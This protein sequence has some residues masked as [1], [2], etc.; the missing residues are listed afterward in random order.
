MNP[1]ER[2]NNQSGFTLVETMVAVMI[3]G[4]ALGACVMSFSMAMRATA[5]AGNQ[6]A[7]LHVARD[8][9]ETLRTYSFGSSVLNAGTYAFTNG[10]FTGSYVI[11]NVNSATKNVTVNVAYINRIRRGYST[12][13]LVTS[14]TSTLHP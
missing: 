8:Q 14:L 5:T 4:I 3:L 12:N 2:A 11:S 13:T 1:K 7:A 9:L 10:T 6:M